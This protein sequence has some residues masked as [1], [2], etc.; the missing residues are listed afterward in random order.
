MK[1]YGICLLGLAMVWKQYGICLL[2]MVMVSGALDAQP[3]PGD[4]FREYRWFHEEG[5]AG[6]SIRVGGK[7]GQEHPD[8]GSAH[9]YINAPFTWPFSVDLAAATRAEVVIEKIMCHEETTGLAIQING[10]DWF[11]FPEPAHIPA[12]A[13]RYQYHTYPVLRIPLS[14][15]KSGTG[16]A[17]RLRVDPDHPWNWPQN[18][19]NGVHLRIYYDPDIKQHAAGA[20]ASLQAGD[21]LGREVVLRTELQTPDA[22]ARIDYVGLYED[23]NL[24]GDGVYRQWHYLYFHGELRHHIGSAAQAPFSLRWDT[25]WLP[26][27]R[28]AMQICARITDRE[29]ITYQS[30]AVGGL[31]LDRPGLSVELCKP[32][33]IP[34][35]WV[36]RSGEKTERFE[37]RGDLARAR[38]AQLVWSSW[39]PGY[40]RGLKIN[41]T[42]VFDREGPNYQTYYHR[43]P[44]MDPGVFRPGTNTLTTGKTPKIN[45]KMVHGMEVNWPGIMVLI[46]Y[47]R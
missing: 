36:T 9:G 16:N 40:M 35:K 3:G 25:R 47:Q 44:L 26:D 30:E 21:R 18:L 12:P 17:F 10:S 4:V 34:P 24:E 7:K 46:Q 27:Q 11:Y 41:G 37:V 28:E 20:I 38:A 22:V 32:Y 42:A 19:I 43:V 33:D 31:I 45:G 5:D 39:S 13:G 2:A 6:Q 29:G 1:Q 15:L 8:R 14:L 23:V